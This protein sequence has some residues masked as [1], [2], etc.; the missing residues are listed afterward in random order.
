MGNISPPSSGYKGHLE[1][2]INDKKYIA[3]GKKKY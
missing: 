1:G 3:W 2:I